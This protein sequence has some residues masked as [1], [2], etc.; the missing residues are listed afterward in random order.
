MENLMLGKLIIP[1]EDE[2]GI[3]EYEWND[4]EMIKIITELGYSDAKEIV[5]EVTTTNSPWDVLQMFK[6]KH[7]DDLDI[8]DL[9]IEMFEQSI[10]DEF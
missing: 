9:T 2:Q 10:K 1:V 8:V 4:S 5:K 6:I 7:N 3:I